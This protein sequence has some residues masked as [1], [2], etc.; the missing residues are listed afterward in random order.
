MAFAG[1]GGKFDQCYRRED[2]CFREIGGV[3]G[4]REDSRDS[5]LLAVGEAGARDCGLVGGNYAAFGQREGFVRVD[6]LLL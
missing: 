1:L 6:G 3:D 2:L 4:G 5:V